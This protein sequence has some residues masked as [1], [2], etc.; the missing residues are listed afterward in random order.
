LRALFSRKALRTASLVASAAAEALTA[1]RARGARRE[2]GR[3]AAAA[4]KDDGAWRSPSDPA[5]A[6]VAPLLKCFL[7]GKR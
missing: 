5:A 2:A 6:I 3:L 4:V 1:N 7:E